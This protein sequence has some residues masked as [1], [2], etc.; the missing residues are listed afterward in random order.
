VEVSCA[1]AVL[2]RSGSRW[3]SMNAPKPTAAT[4]NP[5]RNTTKALDSGRRPSPGIT[6]GGVWATGHATSRPLVC[7]TPRERG[8]VAGGVRS[9]L[10][11]FV[12][13]SPLSFYVLGYEGVFTNSRKSSPG[14]AFQGPYSPASAARKAMQPHPLL[15]RVWVL[16]ADAGRK[17]LMVTW[18]E[19]P[20]PRSRGGDRVAAVLDGLSGRRRPDHRGPVQRRHRRL[21]VPIA[22]HRVRPHQGHL[23][24]SRRS[25]PATPHR[26]PH[27]PTQPG[28]S[29]KPH[30]P[31]TDPRA[32]PFYT[33]TQNEPTD[34]QAS[35]SSTPLRFERPP[36]SSISACRI[37]C[38]IRCL[39]AAIVFKYACEGSG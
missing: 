29:I 30:H 35:P 34:L 9:D 20:A 7:F 31:A 15:R 26:R 32:I 6:S 8:L 14:M 22:P 28:N 23:Q 37:M 13:W 39:C 10:R 25:Q 38:E 21:P 2:T 27:R 1:G 3:P 12:A 5:A 4:A 17:S 33:S 24:Q 36:P 18:N 16:V 19:S 11:L